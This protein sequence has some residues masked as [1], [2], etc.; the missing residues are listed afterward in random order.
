MISMQ[1]WTQSPQIMALVAAR[2]F[3]TSF[4]F[5]PQKEHAATTIGLPPPPVSGNQRTHR[6]ND[7]RKNDTTTPPAAFAAA[8][9]TQTPTERKTMNSAPTHLRPATRAWFAAVVDDFE[10][11]LHHLRL[12]TLAA[13]AWDRCEQAREAIAEHGPVFTDRFGAPRPRPEIAIERDSRIAFAR[14]VRELALDVEPPPDAS[15]PP[16]LRN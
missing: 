1:Y 12:L 16:A 10:L 8:A 14:L 4:R 5:F 15:R 2:S 9:P 11:E 3:W 7:Q 6:Q 13:E